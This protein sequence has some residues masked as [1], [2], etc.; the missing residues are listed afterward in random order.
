MSMV[1]SLLYAAMVTRPDIAFAV[2]RLSRHLQ[3]ARPED[4]AAGKRV[5]RY[6]QG[7][8]SLG[9]IYRGGIET[10]V[11]S[12]YSDSDWAGDMDT[13]R[14][15]T[16][17]V[18]LVSGGCVSWASRLQPTVALSSTEAE[19]MAACAAVQEAI[20]LRGSSKRLGR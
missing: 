5:M 1:G 13:R 18:Y 11:L 12:G 20:H 17:F 6:L 10:P 2:Q 15:T 7:T 3:D 19:Y 8:L 16:G 4:W 9:I 14:S